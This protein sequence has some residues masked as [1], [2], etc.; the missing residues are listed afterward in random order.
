MDGGVLSVPFD[1]LNLFYEKYI[2]AVK[3][4][5]KLFIVEQKSDTYNFFVDLDYKGEKSLP[6]DETK[7]ICK[8]ICDKV[9][10]HGG[11]DCLISVAPPKKSGSKIKTGIHLNWHGMVVDQVSAIALREHILVALTRA[12]GSYDWNEIVD[13]SVYGNVSR[14]ARGSGFRMPW[15]LKMVKHDTCGG[16][17]C[18]ECNWKKKVEQLA[19]LPLFV[20]KHGPLSTILNITPD[21]DVELLKMAAVRTNEPQN[22]F[23]ESPS[24]LVKEGS[25]TVAQMKDEVE[26]DEIKSLVENFIQKN[27]EGQKYAL[28]TKMYKN[29]NT[30]FV[31]TTSR[32][33][34]NLKREHGSN[35]VWFYISG[36]VIAQKCFCRCETLQ[37]RRDGFCKDFYGRKHELPLSITEKLYSNKEE[38]KHCPEIKKIVEKTQTNQHEAKELLEKFINRWM[39]GQTNTKVIHVKKDGANFV[40]LTT[41]DFCETINGVHPGSTMSYVIKKKQITQKCPMCKKNTSRTHELTPNVLKVLKQ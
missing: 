34:E 26:S 27:M 23:V 35:H 11:K 16:Q 4:G 13:S 39:K 14:R 28:V 38:I 33:C 21:P 37:G 18:E 17:G 9:K 15:S 41:S 36:R 10:R 20:Y 25:F 32:Y 7:E 40:V 31:S 12:K 30:Y 1:K 8:I 19:Y 22:T 24:T 2:E 5:E 3:K 6:I 29:K